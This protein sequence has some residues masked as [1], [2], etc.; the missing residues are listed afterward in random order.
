[1]TTI[2]FVPSDY[3][4]QRQSSRTN[5]LYLVLLAVL[6]GGIGVTFSI[7]KIRQAAVRF[8][9]D[10]LS[11]RMAQAREQM[12][13]LEQLK[14]RGKMMMKSMTMTAELLEPA[15]RSVILACLTNTLPSGVS[16]LEVQLQEK[17]VKMS[18]ST[19]AADNAVKPGGKPTQ[20]QS[21]AAKNKAAKQPSAEVQTVL[22]TTLEVSGIAYSDIEVAS[23]IANLSASVL[24]DSVQLIQSK[25]QEVA[26][27]TYRQFR[28][29]MSLKPNLALTKEDIAGIRKK[30]E[31]TS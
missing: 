30:R 20:Y 11:T 17:E 21:A 5:L 12:T 8:E 22:Q 19:G 1:M 26:G 6:L 27:V 28:L 25:E 2:N 9:L 4:Q 24:L 3:I 31:Q 13:R 10:R 18:S 16:L 29:R 7:I 14:S 23:Y 15:P